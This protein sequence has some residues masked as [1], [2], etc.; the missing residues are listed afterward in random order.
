MYDEFD[1][2]EEKRNLSNII[3]S[4]NPTVLILLLLVNDFYAFNIGI[5]F[6]EDRNV[7]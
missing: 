3:S 5:D 1:L 4:L 7:I 2:Q 6:F